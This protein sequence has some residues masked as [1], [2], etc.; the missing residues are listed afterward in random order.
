LDRVGKEKPGK[1]KPSL[2]RPPAESPK[3]PRLDIVNKSQKK[4]KGKTRSGS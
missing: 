3:K 1:E 4:G 2:Q